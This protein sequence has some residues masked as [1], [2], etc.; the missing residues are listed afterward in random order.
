MPAADCG[1]A[2]ARFCDDAASCCAIAS[3]CRVV[4][5]QRTGGVG[6][7]GF[8]AAGAGCA[9]AAGTAPTVARGARIK[10]AGWKS[11]SLGAESLRVVLLVI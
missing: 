7:R 8:G 11:L 10:K 5:G 1:A 3:G 6:S 2:L 4:N 9:A